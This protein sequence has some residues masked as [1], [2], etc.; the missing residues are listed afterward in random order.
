[1]ARPMEE[2][3]RARLWTSCAGCTCGE[4]SLSQ[5]CCFRSVSVRAP[6]QRNSYSEQV[7]HT[8]LGV[9]EQRASGTR[10]GKWVPPRRLAKVEDLDS[11]DGKRAKWEYDAYTGQVKEKE[12]GR[13]KK[14][15]WIKRLITLLLADPWDVCPYLGHFL[16]DTSF[17]SFKVDT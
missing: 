6:S 13:S 14:W 5:V 11:A 2:M 16:T 1:M 4:T 8:D 17:L 3:A 15:C 7:P 9:F 12:E 10:H